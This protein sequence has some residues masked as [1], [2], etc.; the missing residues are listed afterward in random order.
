MSARL[1]MHRHQH[2]SHGSVLCDSYSIHS[3]VSIPDPAANA[4]MNKE[5]PAPTDM[6]F[7]MPFDAG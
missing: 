7:E 6:Q 5:A 3:R 1:H 2:C 4:G